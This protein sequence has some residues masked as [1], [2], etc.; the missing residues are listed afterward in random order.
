MS[1]WVNTQ[2]VVGSSAHLLTQ[3]VGTSFREFGS[4]HKLQDAAC[5]ENLDC[6]AEGSSL[7]LGPTGL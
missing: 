6:R 4:N 5:K 2:F 3:V 7:N 1:G